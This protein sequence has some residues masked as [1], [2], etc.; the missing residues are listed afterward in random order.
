MK[1]I[2]N[3]VSEIDASLAVAYSQSMHRIRNV[4]KHH[5][6]IDIILVVVMCTVCGCGKNRYESN[7]VVFYFLLYIY[8]ELSSNFT[9]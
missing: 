1:R 6:S 4:F 8:I 3:V 5:Y 7:Y 2:I 9:N